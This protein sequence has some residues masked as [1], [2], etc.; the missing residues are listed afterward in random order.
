MLRIL[1]VYCAV[2]STAFTISAQT[3]VQTIRGVVIDKQSSATIPGA[4]IIVLNTTP[5]LGGITD[6]EGKFELKNVPIGRVSLQISS[7]G[8]HTI[9]L[10]NLVLNAGKELVLNISIEEKVSDLKEAV[11]S[12]RSI[13]KKSP[14]QEMATVSARSFT[15]DE[16]NRYAGALGDP[17]RMAT[18]YA[19]VAVAGDARNDIVIRG[20]SPM[21]LLW[22]LDGINIPNPNH[23]GAMGTTGGPVSIL[24]NNL[25]DNS[26]FMTGAFPA[27]Y[28]NA[29]S[30]VFDL[31]MRRGNSENSEFLA[32]VGMNGFELGAEGPLSKSH[33][34]SYLA[35]YRYST[36]GVIKAMGLNIGYGSIP[37][38]QD[39]TFKIDLPTGAKYGRFSIFGIGGISYIE[40][41]DKD[42]KEDDFT[43]S[44]FAEDTYFGS[45]MGALGLTHKIFLNQKTSQ[46][47]SLATSITQ[48]ETKVDSL[49][50][51]KTSKITR[52]GNKSQE[53][54]Y[55]LVY[56][57]NSK[58]NTKNTFNG[59]VYA[60][61]YD[62]NHRDSL[63]M[64]NSYYELLRDFT[65][66]GVLVQAFARWQHKF[67]DR[68]T[69]NSGL[70][71]QHFTLNNTS[72]FEPRL[73]LRYQLAARQTLSAAV[74][75]HSQLQPMTTYFIQTYTDNGDIVRTNKNLG[76]SQSI[77]YVVAH[78]F[79][80]TENWRTKA[81]VYYQ[82]LYNIPIEQTSSSFSMLNAGADYILPLNDSLVN[83][84]TGTNA[85]IE[86][87]IEK[88][89]SHNYY[90]LI[91][92]SF[93]D[94]KYK[95]SDG[96]E[97]N[98]AFNGN[99]TFNVLA[100]AEFNLDKNKKNIITFN[101]KA[102]YAG[103]KRYVPINLAGS[104]AE[105]QATYFDERA[106]EK[107][108]ADYSRIDLKAGYKRNGKHITQ[109]WA[110]DIQN[111]LNTKNIFQQVYNPVRKNIQTEYQLGLF[112][113]MTYR[114]TF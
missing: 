64:Q 87:T 21:G 19:G 50:N 28:G 48:N 65:G 109:E 43:V 58:I 13:D 93:Y 41:L 39:L 91:T 29:L 101:I 77:H 32:Q 60:D 83:D 1:L 86:L 10:N 74:G 59:G 78:D 4:S 80:I 75:M 63:L 54:K 94:S 92:A 98:T 112:P 88:F 7:V 33:K 111:I 24:N 40:L 22:R 96:T 104:N 49:I 11:I 95:G 3:P 35:N 9:S 67:S 15:I 51:D 14:L 103:G 110:F 99:Y 52:Y 108:Y 105:G 37:Q 61:L 18:N 55:S 56:Q 69:L 30:G 85:G 72:A 82:Q 44:G 114:V 76:M 71:Y 107:R 57:I 6:L 79:S 70:H 97:R 81:E 89:F 31:Q 5:V 90:A 34:G 47:I 36:L 68:L 2:L 53:V 25:L 38:Y 106:Y 27:G 12:A 102:N 66:T 26:D 100:G 84:G 23:F 45:N 73:G 46:T 16:T 62:F 113:M 20:N 17:S 8:Y 42:K